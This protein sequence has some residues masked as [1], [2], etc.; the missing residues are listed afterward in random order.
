MSVPRDRWPHSHTQHDR[1]P[2]QNPHLP[3]DEGNHQ[4]RGDGQRNQGEPLEEPLEEDP[5]E[6]GQKEELSQPHPWETQPQSQPARRWT[7]HR[8]SK[9]ENLNYPIA[10]IFFRTILYL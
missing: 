3:P 4:L 5:L 6:E 7:A 8:Q 2:A 1:S 10:N 9:F